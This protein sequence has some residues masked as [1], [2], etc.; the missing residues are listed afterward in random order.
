MG[1]T[2]KK[3]LWKSLKAI[4]IGSVLLWADYKVNGETSVVGFLRKARE[5][6]RAL[7]ARKTKPNEPII[8]DEYE[9]H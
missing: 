3:I 5:L 6:K 8:V 9:I 2:G 4:G 7:T 1:E